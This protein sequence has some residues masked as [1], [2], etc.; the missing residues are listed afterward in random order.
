MFASHNNY[1]FALDVPFLGAGLVCSTTACATC[2]C[3]FRYVGAFSHGLDCCAICFRRTV[4]S[5][6][7]A[8]GAE[9]SHT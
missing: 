4:T 2:S 7:I 9:A 8:A 3:A 6:Q 5:E 1:F